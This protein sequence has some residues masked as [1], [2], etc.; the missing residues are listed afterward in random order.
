M[1]EG[2]LPNPEV[3]FMQDV[4]N[5]QFVDVVAKFSKARRESALQRYLSEGG[6]DEHDEYALV[7]S[8]S[9]A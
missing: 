7:S 8:R 6:H 2:H 1:R 5:E 9:R 3:E 4:G